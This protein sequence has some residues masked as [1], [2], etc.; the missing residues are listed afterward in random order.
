MLVDEH[1]SYSWFQVI[2]NKA[3]MDIFWC[4]SSWGH[5]PHFSSKYLGVALPVHR[6]IAHLAL[7]DTA[8]QFS[9][10]IVPFQLPP[11]RFPGVSDNSR[12]SASLPT[13]GGVSVFHLSH[14]SVFSRNFSTFMYMRLTGLFSLNV[15]AEVSAHP[16]KFLI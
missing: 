7:A 16:Q 3:T 6:K 10:V 4:M 12:C 8:G 5:R 9:K 14:V 2:G 15:D 1:L 13:L 11:S